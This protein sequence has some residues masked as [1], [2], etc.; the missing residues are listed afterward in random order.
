LV[1]IGD[2]VPGHEAYGRL[3]REEGGGA[4]FWMGRR[5]HD[6]P[7][8]ASLYAAGRVLALPSWFETPGLVALEAALAGR[9]VVITPHGCTREYFGDRVGYARPDRPREIARAL[10][11]AWDRGPHP[12]LADHVR[13]RFLWSHAGRATMEAYDHVA[14]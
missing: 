1:V 3:C 7:W 2:I 6:D 4:V 11:S 14:G 9:A 10:R 8:L 12:D 5:D 13:S